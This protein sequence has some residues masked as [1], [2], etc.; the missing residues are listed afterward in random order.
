MKNS[1]L[2]LLLFLIIASATFCNAQNY[3]A[4]IAG[5]LSSVANV[6]I[7]P[8]GPAGAVFVNTNPAPLYLKM[9]TLLYRRHLH[10][11]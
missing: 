8:D 10:F 4:K 9:I 2:L 1:V 7:G 11:L 3:R 5:G 6:T